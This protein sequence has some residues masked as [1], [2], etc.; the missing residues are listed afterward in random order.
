MGTDNGIK[1]FLLNLFPV[2]VPPCHTAFVGAEVFY[3]PADRLN[4]GLATVPARLATVEF[5][6]TANVGTDGA[7]RDAQHQ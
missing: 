5:R 2:A 3:L 7:G 1:C 4:H 6:V